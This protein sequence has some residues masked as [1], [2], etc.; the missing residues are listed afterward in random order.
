MMIQRKV[1]NEKYDV[2]YPGLRGIY[3]YTLSYRILSFPV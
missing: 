1:F 3:S 2:Y